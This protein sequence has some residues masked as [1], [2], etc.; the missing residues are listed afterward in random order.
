MKR[1]AFTLI[2]L[3]VVV[4]IIGIL[5]ALLFP[6]FAQAREKA[7]QTVCLS[8]TRQIGTAYALYTTD[9]D[10]RLPLTLD[11]PGS[12][13]TDQCQPYLKSRDVFRCPS[14]RSTNWLSPLPGK[15][16][17]RKASY[18]LSFSMQ[19]TSLWGNT[20]AIARPA[21]VIYLAESAENGTG[22][23]FHPAD[24][25]D[26]CEDGGTGSEWNTDTQEPIELSTRRHQDGSN[27]GY[28]DGHAKWAKFST[29]WFRDLPHD[30]W[31]GHFDPRQ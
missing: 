5:A 29:L 20:A 15:K 14:D 27:Y 31:T 3:L 19:G 9:Y 13:W 26:P 24:W 1:L 28:V 25:G 18:F 23:H 10:G 12:S 16:S 8:N 4:A 17:L 30:I 22:D 6:V 2:E 7:R 21:S 11:S